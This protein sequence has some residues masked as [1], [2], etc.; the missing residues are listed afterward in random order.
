MVLA[1]WGGRFLG[2]LP[3]HDVGD[4]LGRTGLLLSRAVGILA[5]ALIFYLPIEPTLLGPLSGPAYWFARLLPDGLIVL[6]VAA[7]LWV[8]RHSFGS[9]DRLMVMIVA[10]AIT[11]TAVAEVRDQSAFVA[12]NSLRVL[13]RYPLLGLA[14][15][16]WGTEVPRIHFRVIQVIITAGAI[17]VAI[18]LASVALTTVHTGSLHDSYLLA[19]TLGR[20]DRYGPVL[21]AMIIAMIAWGM[22]AGWRSWFWPLLVTALPLLYLSTSRQAMGGLALACGIAAILSGVTPRMRA[23][24]ATIAIL[25]LAMIILTPRTIAARTDNGGIDPDV[26]PV[27][28]A[29]AEPG[30]G[31]PTIKGGDALSAEPTRNFR[32]FLLLAVAPWA[33]SQEPL[34]GF[35][36]GEQAAEQPDPRIEAFMA[37]SDLKWPDVV[38]YMN[39]SEYASL[40]IQFGLP[41]TAALLALLVGS[42]FV[43]A[44]IALATLEPVARFSLM[45][46]AM[47]LA[48]AFLGPF[49][50]ARTE[51]ILLWIPLL[52]TV[53]IRHPVHEA[54]GD[55]GGLSLPVQQLDH[56]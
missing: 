30:S 26:R 6:L 13:L 9:P 2:Q 23:L 42:L 46:G 55:A 39:D 3:G 19:G 44:R 27:P 11:I 37:I 24:A 17:Q 15:W 36:P 53:G 18:G 10:V 12:V 40:L 21:A 7:T 54:H 5:L 29:S 47:A 34:V 56:G 45:Y 20:Y 35:G 31:T 32:L 1:D 48:A 33:V 49:F 8:D 41:A 25:A 16:R 43:A 52:I 51:S 50:E 14:V 4:G 22:N 38:A 28:G